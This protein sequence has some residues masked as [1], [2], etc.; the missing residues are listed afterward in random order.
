MQIK[1]LAGKAS[2]VL[3]H[4]LNLIL[5][6]ALGFHFCIFERLFLWFEDLFDH[7]DDFRFAVDDVVSHLVVGLRK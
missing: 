7:A 3:S 1:T 5:L 6:K 2:A 4:V